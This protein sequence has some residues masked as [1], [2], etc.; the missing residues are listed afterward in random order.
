MPFGLAEV[1][2][3]EASWRDTFAWPLAPATVFDAATRLLSRYNDLLVASK[4]D[5]RHVL[6]LGRSFNRAAALMEAALAIQHEND[7]SIRLGGPNDLAVL[8]G[9]KPVEAGIESDSILMRPSGGR[10]DFPA[11]RR[12]VRTKTWSSWLGLPKALWWPDG[13][14][15]T[16][17]KLLVADVRRRS[18]ALRYEA[19]DVF[20]HKCLEGATGT[21]SL[22][23]SA[24]DLEKL[25]DAKV[26]ALLND[27]LL[28]PEMHL[29]LRALLRPVV[30]GDLFKA[31]SVLAALERSPLIPRALWSGTGGYYPARALGLAAMR[32]GGTACRYDHGGTASLMADTNFLASQELAVSTELVMPTPQAAELVAPTARRL[33]PAPVGRITGN[34]GD[35][36]LDPGRIWRRATIPARRRV[37]YVGG[38][39]YGFS[40]TFPPFPPSPVYIDWQHRLLAALARLPVDL[41]HKPHP[42]AMMRGRPSF[43]AP[44]APMLTGWFEDALGDADVV[45]ID[46]AATTTLAIAMCSDRPLVLFDFGCMP[47]NPFVKDQVA[48]RCRIIPVGHDERN[49]LT[50]D[51]AAMAEAVCCGPDCADPSYF[52]SLFLGR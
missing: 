3:A 13:L 10:A 46:L 39:Y 9:D 4:E 38:P 26:D 14:V 2:G 33:E 51:E 34:G 25:V 20:L 11:L 27:P 7:A 23:A 47:F 31:D 40:Q 5:E 43:L 12:V 29:R 22:F 8:R 15:V 16:H 35:P 6:L 30:H 19:A 18:L 50:L 48:R 41:R 45:I 17:N 28:A 44:Y 37:I 21:A 24:D 1:L 32:R 42:G 52:R 36:S 49:R